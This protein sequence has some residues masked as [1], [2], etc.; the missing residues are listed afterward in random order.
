ML[1]S[2][3]PKDTRTPGRVLRCRP[4][5]RL[6]QRPDSWQAP[7]LTLEKRGR[8][9]RVSAYTGAFSDKCRIALKCIFSYDFLQFLS[10]SLKN[11]GGVEYM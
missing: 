3:P 5:A 10:R 11:T 6:P 1:L 4:P 2:C 7:R 9:L 8:V